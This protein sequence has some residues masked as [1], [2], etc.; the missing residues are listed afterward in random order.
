[1]KELLTIKYI[2]LKTVL[3]IMNNLKLILIIFIFLLINKN[4]LSQPQTEW[5]Q[6]YNSSLM[7]NKFV[8]DMSVDKSG[9]VYVTGYTLNSSTSPYDAVFF[10]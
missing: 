8:T 10:A 6:K 3:I 9:N 5:V 2:L 1:M 4:C 7:Y